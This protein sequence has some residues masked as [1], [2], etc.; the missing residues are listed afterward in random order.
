MKG[1]IDP[2]EREPV[3]AFREMTEQE[4]EDITTSSQHALRS[5]S[6]IKNEK[7][8]SSRSAGFGNDVVPLVHLRYL[9][10]MML[11]AK[12]DQHNHTTL[13]NCGAL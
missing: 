11:L 6:F 9:T 1:I 8:E 5:V 12:F 13:K 7:R 4:R 10:L 2:C 3:D